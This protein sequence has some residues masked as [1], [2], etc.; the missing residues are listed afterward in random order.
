MLKLNPDGTTAWAAHVRIGSLDSIREDEGSGI[1]VDSASA[2]VGDH[3]AV[4]QR[5]D[6]GAGPQAGPTLPLVRSELDVTVCAFVN[7]E[8]LLGIGSGR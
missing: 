1:A 3:P 5:K 7:Q 4:L 6:G 8:L 2:A